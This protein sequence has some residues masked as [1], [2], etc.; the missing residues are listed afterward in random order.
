MT[1]SRI[2]AAVTPGRSEPREAVASESASRMMS[3]AGLPYLSPTKIVAC[4]FGDRAAQGC[5]VESVWVLLD[6]CEGSE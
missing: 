2:L 5:F 1:C 3:C 4:R 6:E